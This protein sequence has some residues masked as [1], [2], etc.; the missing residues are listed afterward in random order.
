MAI[1]G[2][3]HVLKR[4]GHF[5]FTLDV[6]NLTETITITIT[7]QNLPDSSKDNF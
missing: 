7:K 3:I 2:W 5:M 4:A 1:H 6:D